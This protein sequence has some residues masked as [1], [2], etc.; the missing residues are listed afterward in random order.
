[1]HG[2]LREGRHTYSGNSYK[3]DLLSAHGECLLSIQQFLELH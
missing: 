2:V 3:I 1:M